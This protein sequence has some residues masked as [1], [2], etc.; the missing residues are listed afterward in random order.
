MLNGTGRLSDQA[1]V[2][3]V[4]NSEKYAA[5]MAGQAALESASPFVKRDFESIGRDCSQNVEVVFR[6]MSSKG[7]YQPQ[8]AS[9]Q[10]S[11]QAQ[12]Q[13]S[14]M[15]NGITGTTTP[16]M[17]MSI[18]QTGGGYQLGRAGGGQFGYG[19]L[20]GGQTG[21]GMAG[22]GYG[23]AGG[24]G[25]GGAGFGGQT[26][27]GGGYGSTLPGGQG[28]SPGT[29]TTGYGGE[30]ISGRGPSSRATGGGSRRRSS[31]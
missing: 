25:G 19:T 2:T 23:Q 20:G 13:A 17:T 18:G 15:I 6:V 29:S 11:S 1:I 27:G 9:P 12:Q 21:Y 8:P 3:D 30:G 7:W 14:T 26:G 5:G 31:T 22:G 4:L 28:Y 10:S 16:S 24:Y